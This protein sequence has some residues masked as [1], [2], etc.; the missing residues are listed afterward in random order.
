MKTLVSVNWLS[1]HLEQ[2][3]LVILD[4]SIKKTAFGSISVSNAYL[5]NARPFDIKQLFSFSHN[6]ISETLPKENQFEKV[7]QELGINKTSSI[8]V[9]DNRG[10]Y[11]SPR[12]WWLFKAMGH[13]NI[14]VLNGGLPEWINKALPTATDYKAAWKRGNFKAQFNIKTVIPFEDIKANITTPKFTLIDARSATRFNGTSCE[15]RAHIKSGCIPGS[16]NIPYTEVLD[17]HKY[18]PLEALN[19]IFNPYNSRNCK[20]VYSCGS[21]ITACIVLLAGV[22]TY[23]KGISLY[24]G[25]WTEWAEKNLLFT[26]NQTLKQP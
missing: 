3:D 19:Q 25:S 20:L 17:G 13:D 11:S 26:A 24:A 12:V 6:T 7:C 16:I 15:P 8:V 23:N 18:K 2:D 1:S 21:G 4:A 5:P 14:A 9:Y 22:I 10:I